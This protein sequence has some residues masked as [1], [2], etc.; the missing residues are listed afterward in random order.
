MEK[1]VKI[2]ISTIFQNGGEAT[3][4][5]EMA[6]IIRK[7]QP[8]DY[9]AEIIFLSHSSPFEKIAREEG[10][11]VCTIEPKAKFANFHDDFKTRF[12]ELIGDYDVAKE[13]LESEI[14]IYKRLKPDIV[15]HGFYPIAGIAKRMITP[16]IPSIAFLPLPLTEN[17]LDEIKAFPDELPMARLPKWLQKFVIKSIPR[18]MMLKNPALRHSVIAQAAFDLGWDKSQPLRGTF[19]MLRSENY[20]INDFPFFYK[21]ENYE[22]NFLFTGAIYSETISKENNDPEIIKWLLADNKRKKVFCTLGTSGDKH[23]LI[24]VIKVFNEGEGK[25]WSAI[26][27]SPP[28]ICDLEEAKKYVKNSNVYITNQFVNAKEINEKADVV[29][30]HGG[31]GTLQT[32]ITSRTP[33]VGIAT[34]PEQQIN[35]EHLSEFGMAERISYWNWKATYIRKKVSKILS[36]TTYKEKAETLNKLSQTIPTKQLIGERVWDIIKNLSL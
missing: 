3:R 27:L 4:A 28:A 18:K 9:R 31:Q 22:G 24:E 34:Q 8:N 1:K 33:L 7:H 17:Y 35:L 14:A 2:I 30:C 23:H 19:D 5:L 10:F 16:H 11:E 29:I 26:I 15:L 13:Y 12:G 25:Q 21:K 6:K 32:A 20:L 36:H